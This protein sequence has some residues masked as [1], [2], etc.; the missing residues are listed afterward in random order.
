M[1]KFADIC[2]ER[3]NSHPAEAVEFPNG[4]Y[5][6]FVLQLFG[7]C[8]KL[9]EL[10]SVGGAKAPKQNV[11]KGKKMT[12][13]FNVKKVQYEGTDSKNDFAFKFYNPEQIILGKTM[14]ERLPFAM[15]WW[16]NLCQ[17]RQ[18]YLRRRY[19]GIKLSA[20][21]ANPW[22]MQSQSGA[23]FE[24][25]EKLGIEY[26]CFHDLDLVPEADDI[27]ETNARTG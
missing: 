24:M 11:K 12:D 4:T 10:G 18:G 26:F 8:V 25:M 22:S 7:K 9:G 20:Q 23:G 17:R 16:H 13:Y 2:F 5:Q 6:T 27:R 19:R 15:A 21:N 3:K 14:K 1:H